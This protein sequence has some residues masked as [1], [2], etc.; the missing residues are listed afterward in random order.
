M[1]I[2]LTIIGCKNLKKDF[3]KNNSTFNLDIL[4]GFVVI[5]F[6]YLDR[7]ITNSRKAQRNRVFFPPHSQF[8]LETNAKTSSTRRRWGGFKYFVLSQ[9]K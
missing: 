7:I 9:D 6:F 4:M 2:K 1:Q 8:A 3:V 5:D